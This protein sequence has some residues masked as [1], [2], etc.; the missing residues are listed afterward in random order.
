V[1]S[2][3]A[4]ASAVG[5][6]VLERGG[7]AVD[8][9]IAVAFALGVTLPSAGNIG[10]GGFMLVRSP[11]GNSV[12]IDY[13]E[14]APRAAHRDMFLDA[15]GEVTDKGQVGPLAA[16]IP[17]V[18]AG[19]WYAH[20]KYGSLPWAEL[21]A[22]AV[23]LAR[24]GCVLDGYGAR[25][26]ERA[27]F[28]IREYTG[29]VSAPR[30]AAQDDAAAA[31][32]LDRA[33]ADTLATFEKPNARL[34]AAGETWK[35]PAL[36]DTLALIARDGE[37]AFYSGPLAARLAE[38]VRAMGGIWSRDDLSSYRVVPREPIAFSYHG[39]DV[40]T[41]PPPSGGG[42]VL[43]QILAGADA[44][45]LSQLSWDSPERVHDYVEISRRAFADRNRWLGDPDFVS[46]P[47]A[48]LLDP[49]RMAQR[50]SDIDPARA[51]PS[52]RVQAGEA[53]VESKHTTHFSVVDRSGMAVA[54]TFTL[55]TSFGA[56]VQIPGTGITLN[57]E[58]DDFTAKAGTPNLF[59]LVQGEQ[60]SIQPGKRM[61]SSMSPTIVSRNRA[62]R[63]VLGSPGGST[64]PTTVAQILLQLVDHHRS[65]A[66][67]V[68]APRIHHQWWPD[69]L[70]YE[71]A[72]P[73][74]LLDALRARGHQ[75]SV[76][77]E[78]IGHANCIEVDGSTG[79]RRAVADIVRGG[80]GAVAY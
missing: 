60:N 33:L 70:W 15:S 23:Q 16:G 25:D 50:L 55:N 79:E 20:T 34:Y 13:R 63:A 6:E 32:A 61:L 75:V 36:G 30:L 39:Y 42:V 53:R 68:A 8:S 11:D 41:M 54:N 73:T 3:E 1:S 57:N 52:N 43:R 29:R 35:Q 24:E 46:V 77:D 44:R 74:S 78:P 5:L 45:A 40:L 26:L 22:P 62:V 19:L 64:I 59:E 67:A 80:G 12:A 2:A 72:V 18:V 65:L 27:V 37:R 14:V 48:A 58:M 47:L 49:A 21:V 10:G 28:A 31:Q 51:T 76:A 66:D 17:G 56:L 69:E 38:G 9:A 4:A 7:N 71:P